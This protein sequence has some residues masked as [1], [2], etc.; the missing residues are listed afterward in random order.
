M[1]QNQDHI[2]YALSE[3]HDEGLTYSTGV[4]TA[5]PASVLETRIIPVSQYLIMPGKGDPSRQLFDVLI[6]QFF[7]R[8]LPQHP[9][10]H[11]GNSFVVEALLNSNP[12]TTDSHYLA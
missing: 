4:E 11:R 1:S 10:L 12:Q 6:S 7:N 8:A 9:N 5:T 3:V 2:G